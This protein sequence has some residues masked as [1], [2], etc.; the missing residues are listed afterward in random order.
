V[1]SEYVP[2]PVILDRRELMSDFTAGLRACGYDQAGCARRLGVFPR[3]GVSFWPSM[4]LDWVPRPAEALDTLVELFIDG[5]PVAADRLLSHLPQA[6]VDAA[7]EMRLLEETR[8]QLQAR[9]C[10]FPCYGTYLA[11]DRVPKNTAINQV[12]WLWGES[13]LLGGM[14]KRAPRRRAV[15][16]GTG[17]GV[18]A[19]LAAR[20]SQ[21]VTAVDINPRAL[22]FARF[23]ACLNGLTN[24]EFVLSDVFDAVAGTCDL[25]VANPPYAPDDAARAGDNFWSGGHDG[26]EILRRIVQALPTRLDPDGVAHIV[27]LYPN[28][29][30]TRLRDH[31]D[32]W[33]DGAVESYEALDHTWPVPRY[34]DMLSEQP[35]RG[36]KS[37]W[38]FG[39]V[40]LRRSPIGRGWW[41]E[42]AGKGGFFDREGACSVVADHDAI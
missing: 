4:R 25:L 32:R 42:A 1:I 7:I 21:S 41:K 20:H 40:S 5:Q 27:A 2:P 38:R 28:P 6:L 31:F 37:A 11:T 26:M 9:L 8:A 30:G 3:L 22:E 23:N 39:V 24:L 15:D 18:H 34:E 13:Y 35:F 36:D 12:M 14:V 29:A 33:L 17:S 16:I 10:L 19:V